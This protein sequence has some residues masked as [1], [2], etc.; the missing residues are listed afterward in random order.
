MG[1]NA[2]L[3]IGASNCEKLHCNARAAHRKLHE[4]FPFG[5][6]AGVHYREV[7]CVATH[8]SYIW[9][10]PRCAASSRWLAQINIRWMYARRVKWLDL[11]GSVEHRRALTQ[12]GGERAQCDRTPMQAARAQQTRRQRRPSC[13][14][15][16]QW[17][18]TRTIRADWSFAMAS[19]SNS[20]L[21]PTG[22]T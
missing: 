12:F 17:V 5:L 11:G 1:V 2:A 8:V 19:K 6:V 16:R 15:N 22:K 9:H 4:K 21:G 20:W 10:E 18:T 13:A 14:T 7:I 3:S